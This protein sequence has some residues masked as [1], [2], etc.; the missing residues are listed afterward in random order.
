MVLLVYTAVNI[1]AAWLTG[2]D[3]W[4]LYGEFFSV[5]FRLIGKQAPIEYRCGNEGTGKASVS[6][7]APFLALVSERAAHFSL[8]LFVL[9]MLSS[10]AFD[11]IHETVPWVGIFWR[12]VYPFLAMFIAT[13]DPQ[14]YLVL[15]N[16]FYYW[17]WLMLLV[18][19]FIYLAIYLAFVA[20]TKLVTRSTV[21]VRELA[22]QFAFSLVPIAFVYNVTHYFTL[23]VS[24]GPFIA[25]LISDP[26]G[27]NWNLFGTK[28]SYAQPYMLEAGTVWH[29]QVA[30]ILFG[31]I[32]SV[33]IAHVQALKVFGSARK[34]TVSQIPLLLLM[35]MLTT[36]GLWILSLPI[37]AGQVLL[38]PTP[39]G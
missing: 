7:R 11:G 5:F 25:P 28:G 4:F 14:Q 33:Y 1:F 37:A 38:P 12:N 2:K 13:N 18:S 24:Q 6:L 23:L 29:I 16:Y 31:H 32:V 30:L 15:V 39:N 27:Y 36:I 34:A 26:F 10:T 35:M 17:Q 20:L 9:F 3:A 19:P 22:L 8:L 21:P